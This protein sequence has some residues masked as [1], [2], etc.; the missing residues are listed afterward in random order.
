MNLSRFVIAGVVAATCLG[1]TPS[2]ASQ[3][4]DAF[5]ANAKPN[6]DFLDKTSR[7][8]LERS[9][10]RRVKAYAQDV[11][12]RETIVANSLVAV[13]QSTTPAGASAA[14]GMQASEADRDPL[15]P[16]G[17]VA[18]NLA[19]SV[20]RLVDGSLLT[21]RSV[22]LDVP[23]LVSPAAVSPAAT[24][25]S[26]PLLPS[27]QADYET[28]KTLKSQRFDSFYKLTQRNALRQLVAVYRDYASDGDDPA[29]K[30]LSMLQLDKTNDL[31]RRLND[32]R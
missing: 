31:I 24:L 32:L 15:E 27:Q 25:A 28:L 1:A 2:F 14:L 5:F 3:L 17:K 12:A 7:L 4:T 13:W 21:G 10:S 23:A 8:A 29:L 6:V 18:G 11:A 30:S 9:P 19:G 22:A 26:R 20:T 16:L